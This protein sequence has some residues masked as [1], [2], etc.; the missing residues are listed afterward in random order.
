VKIIERDRKRCEELSTLL[1]KATIL[2]GDGSDEQLLQEEGLARTESFVPLTGLDEENI[3]MTLYARRISEC[4]VIT[5]LN[6]VAFRNVIAQLDLGSIVYPRYITAEA[7]I[8]YVRARQ[9]SIGSNIETLYYL[10]D[11]RVEAAEFCVEENA[12]VI[13]IPLAELSL[14]NNL[15][16]ACINR[17]GQII[18]PRGYDHIE[19]GD[20]VIVVT[21]HTGFHDIRDILR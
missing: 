20:T 15:L 7:I 8:A 12:P 14:K 2:H 18:I 9:N 13:G 4:K 21:T 16:I 1:P 19:A 3:L 6:R 11:N 17:G 10:F 5:K